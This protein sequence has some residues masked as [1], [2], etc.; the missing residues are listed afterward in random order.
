MKSTATKEPKV[1]ANWSNYGSGI[2][3]AKLNGH[4][5]LMTGSRG[6]WVAMVDRTATAHYITKREAMAAAEAAAV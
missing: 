6:D 1:T 3:G 5:L 4:D 2:W